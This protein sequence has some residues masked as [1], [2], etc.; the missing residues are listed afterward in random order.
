[1][2]ETPTKPE[3]NPDIEGLASRIENLE[4]ALSDLQKLAHLSSAEVDAK[5]ENALQDISNRIS[6]LEQR[7]PEIVTRT[8]FVPVPTESE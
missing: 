6:A 8:R 3:P 5:I 4:R 1:M 7:E 2:P